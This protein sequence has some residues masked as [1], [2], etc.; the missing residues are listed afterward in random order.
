[1]WFSM[2]KKRLD[3]RRDGRFTTSVQKLA[4]SLANFCQKC[5]WDIF[6]WS[7]ASR[8]G[9][10]YPDLDISRSNRTAG[11]FK[12]EWTA[13]AFEEVCLNCEINSYVSAKL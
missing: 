8:P 4:N 7:I 10:G 12:M 3:C 2:W 1:M 13:P 11:G 9:F 5:A 6:S